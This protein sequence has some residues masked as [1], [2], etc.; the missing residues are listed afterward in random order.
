MSGRERGRLPVFRRPH[1]KSPTPGSSEASISARLAFAEMHSDG[2]WLITS[3]STPSEIM[4][5]TAKTRRRRDA[6]WAGARLRIS[7]SKQ[8]S[9][10]P[11]CP[12]RHRS[13]TSR[14]RRGLLDVPKNFSKK[15]E[16]PALSFQSPTA[17][18]FHSLHS[19]VS[20]GRSSLLQP[21]AP[22]LNAVSFSKNKERNRSLAQLTLEPP[23]SSIHS[24]D[25]REVRLPTIPD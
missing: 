18:L 13:M 4:V 17:S 11:A 2:L 9:C 23:P 15:S 21:R 8:G 1:R 20:A 19:T 24:G 14:Q 22:S 25:S 5:M 7:F 12:A 3:R 6:Y 16:I 10:A